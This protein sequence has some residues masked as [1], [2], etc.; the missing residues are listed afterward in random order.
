VTH[1]GIYRTL[2]I[3]QICALLA[4]VATLV[5]VVSRVSMN[6]VSP[7]VCHGVSLRDTGP[8]PSGDA[9]CALTETRAAP[10]GYRLP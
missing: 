6:T 4:V 1:S 7:G 3:A 8:G 2:S 5:V 9:G 10:V